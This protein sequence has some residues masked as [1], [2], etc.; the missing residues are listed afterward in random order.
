MTLGQGWT[1]CTKPST[2]C[3][4]WSRRPICGISRRLVRDFGLEP[5]MLPDYSSTLDGPI[6]SEY[7]RIP[8]GGTPIDAIRRMGSARATIEFGS[9]WD[10]AHTAGALLEERFGVPR[11]ELPMPIG[12]TQTDRLTEL[13]SELA[14]R[15]LPAVHEEERGRLVDSY[16]DAHKYIFGKRAA[17]LWR[18]RSCRGIG[19]AAGRDR[20][21]A[22]PVRSGGKSRSPARADRRHRTGSCR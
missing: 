14:G 1:T 21:R 5:I 16:V 11:Y 12:V 9:T 6:W 10:R 17:H 13:L 19:L 15:P 22:G 8:P 18:T 4:A 3:P 7:E 2:Y 20:H